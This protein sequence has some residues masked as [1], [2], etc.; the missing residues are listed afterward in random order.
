MLSHTMGRR[1]RRRYRRTAIG[2]K[3]RYGAP[4]GPGHFC[5]TRAH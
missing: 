1:P 3:H 5:T 4:T 2:T